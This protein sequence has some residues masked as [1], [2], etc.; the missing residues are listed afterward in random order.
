MEGRLKKL[1]AILS[2]ILISGCSA[3]N[4]SISTS[5]NRT[6]LDIQKQQ[7]EMMELCNQGDFRGQLYQGQTKQHTVAECRLMLAYTLSD[8]FSKDVT[9]SIYE[10]TG[11]V[12]YLIPV[13]SP[14]NKSVSTTNSSAALETFLI[15]VGAG[16]ANQTT[17]NNTNR[18]INCTTTST[19]YLTNGLITNCY[20]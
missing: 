17:T 19:G 20:K 6:W 3:S 11:E 15:G 18:A 4:T 7:P 14:Q 9:D 1:L 2:I 10:M 5:S 8:V 16:L 12:W 13:G